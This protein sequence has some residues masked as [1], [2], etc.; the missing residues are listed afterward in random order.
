[1]II[2]NLFDD[3]SKVIWS[4][5]ETY[6]SIIRDYLKLI[7]ALFVIIRDLFDPYSSLFE[8]YLRLIHDYLKSK[9]QIMT[10]NKVK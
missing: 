10:N 8:T 4:L 1:M 5:F 3:Y 2:R 9:S 7:W 6:L